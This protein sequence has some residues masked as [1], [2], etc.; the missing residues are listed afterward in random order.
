MISYVDVTK[1]QPICMHLSYVSS[2]SGPFRTKHYLC[3]YNYDNY[4]FFILVNDSYNVER[5]THTHTHTPKH[6]CVCVCV[7]GNMA[8][9]NWHQLHVLLNLLRFPLELTFSE[10]SNLK[11]TLVHKY[12]IMIRPMQKRK[13]V[14]GAYN[15]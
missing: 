6:V 15:A 4:Y 3:D 13:F 12:L 9:I 7:C 14:A 8:I 10:L 11:G 2:Q 5:K 1:I